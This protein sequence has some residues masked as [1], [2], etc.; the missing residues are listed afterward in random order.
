MIPA[1]PLRQTMPQTADFIDALRDAFGAEPVNAAIKNGLA[2]GTDFYAEEN[3]QQLG[4]RPPPP[5]AS[6]TVEQLQLGD[7]PSVPQ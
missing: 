1:K 5:G 4:H 6:F 7:F 2:G 3:G